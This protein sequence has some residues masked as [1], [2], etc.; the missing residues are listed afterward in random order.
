MKKKYF[1][2]LNLL[3]LL[4]L[5]LNS[6]S[7]LSEIKQ[8][9]QSVQNVSTRSSSFTDYYWHNGE[10]I[11]I[12]KEERKKYIL[13]KTSNEA[14]V[15]NGL[16]SLKIVHKPSVVNLSAILKRV[17]TSSSTESL[18]W[19]SV[20]TSESLIK[21]ENIIYEAPYFLSTDGIELGLSHLFYVKLKNEKDINKLTKLSQLNK[22]EII[23]NN[24][25]MPLWYTLSCTKES[26]GNA[27]ILANKF[28]ETKLFAESQPDLM[29]DDLL[30]C[31]NDPLFSANQWNLNNTGQ[32]GGTVGIDVKFCDARTI[33][34][35]SLDVIVAVVDQGIQLNHPDLNVYPISYDSET[36]T[37]PSIVYGAHGTQCAGFI[38]AVTNNSIGIAAIAPSCPSMSISNTM[39]GDPDSRQK[40]ADAINFAWNNGASVISNSWGSSVQYA[41]INDAISNALT[42]GRSGKGCVVVFASGNGYSSTV[43][44]P[45]NSHPDILAVGS[46]NRNGLRS[47]FSDYG[48]ALDI[49]APGEAVCSTTTGSSYVQ[50]ISGTSFACPQVAATAALVL[51]VNP[52][53]TQK[54]V[55]DII[56]STAQ[57]VGNYTYSTTSGRPN[58]TWNNEMGYGLL[59]TFAAVSQASGNVVYFVNQSVT[60]NTDVAGWDIYTQNVT[61]SQSARLNFTIQNHIEI[62]PPFVINTGSKLNISW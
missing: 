31:V 32:S 12:N 56:E 41:I 1:L 16:T 27:L 14:N 61:V 6:C 25:Y 62:E 19:A 48:T 55:A 15:K 17:N 51:S 24:E 53:L 35:G 60:S 38:S 13:F 22:V 43:S 52:D 42:E 58:G 21:N 59:N 9:D 8:E 3:I 5:I 10:K 7:D 36:G 40:R 39:I 34:T 46:I 20:E 4:S 29:S 23:G 33:T 26:A 45:A 28:Y 2:R 49:V 47:S 11:G 18:M 50:L 37:S 54:Q 30:S 44:Y 57:K